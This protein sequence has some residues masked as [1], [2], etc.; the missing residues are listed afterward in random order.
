MNAST[1]PRFTPAG[2]HQIAQRRN[3]FLRNLLIILLVQILVA[4][5][6]YIYQRNAQPDVESK[7]LFDVNIENVDKWVISDTNNKV[8]FTKSKDGW[9]LPDWHQ[10]P[11]D[12]QKF[13]NLVDKLKGTRLTWP[14]TTT[15]ASHDRFEVAETKFQ[16]RLE[17]FVGDKKVGDIFLGSSPGFKKVHLRRADDNEVYAVE[18]S[19][20]ELS[21][22]NKDWLNTS[23]FAAKQPEGI[24]GA[25]YQL[26]KN[27]ESWQL[28]GEVSS[29]IDASKVNGLVEAF[30]GFTVQDLYAGI[31]QGE[32]VNIAVKTN[33]TEWRYEFVKSGSDYFVKRNDR[34]LYFEIS[35]H[36][37]ERFAQLKKQDFLAVHQSD[38]ATQSDN[39][40]TA[41]FDK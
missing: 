11:I 12:P 25:D 37:Y 20:F 29:N 8:T 38:G 2:G 32:R 31:P 17:L 1:Y 5:G 34:D 35:A 23:L 27:G 13:D 26:E 10:L 41:T 3:Y 21:A 30:S 6:I 4:V 28:A 7:A 22:T 39:S 36:E 18:L 33:S 40:A 14:A 19:S 24:I 16:R 9:Q 15:K